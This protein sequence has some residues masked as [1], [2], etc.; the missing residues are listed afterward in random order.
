MKKLMPENYLYWMEKGLTESE[1]KEE[2]NR[3]KGGRYPGNKNYYL[4]SKPNITESEAEELARKWKDEKCSLKKENMIK[5]KFKGNEEEYLKWKMENCSLSKKNLLKSMTKQE[6]IYHKRSLGLKLN[7][8]RPTDMQYW[9]N[10]GFTEEQAK[11]KIRENNIKISKR[12]PEYWMGKGLTLDEAINEVS[13]Y[14]SRNNLKSFIERYGDTDGLVRYNN[15]KYGQAINSK[16]SILYWISNGY[17]EEEAIEQVSI[18]QSEYSKLQPKLPKYWIDMGYSKDDAILKSKEFSRLLCKW[19]IEYWLDMGLTDSEAKTKVSEIQKENSLKGVQSY[20][21]KGRTISSNLEN[22]VQK[23]FINKGFDFIADYIVNDAENKKVYFPDLVFDDFILEVYGD[24]WHG[25]LNI[26]SEDNKIIGDMTVKQKH[27]SDKNRI[28]RIETITKKP[29][30]IW[31]E[32]D[33]LEQGLD[34]IYSTLMRKL[35]EN[36]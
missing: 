25:N 2:A 31:W 15:W 10:K 18:I 16:R 8:K 29:V 12:R 5:N 35:N 26:Y 28:R 11:I 21:H 32:K 17:N 22:N 33:I 24:Y 3:R 27:E 1:A 23:F 20:K 14:Q 13:K 4:L 9:V 6:Y 7:G 30:F 36:N 19:C 34:N